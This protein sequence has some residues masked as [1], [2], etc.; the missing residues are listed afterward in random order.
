MEGD[1]FVL[2]LRRCR[3]LAGDL[4]QIY[5][6]F[7]SLDRSIIHQRGSM[8]HSN[9]EARGGVFGEYDY[10]NSIIYVLA[11]L[12]FSDT[13]AVT[14]DFPSTLTIVCFFFCFFLA[15]VGVGWKFNSATWSEVP[16]QSM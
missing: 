12:L 14:A 10:G 6:F 11:L 13:V 9:R 7:G 15:Q 1:V 2:R 8:L 5:L 4:G 16:I 3:L